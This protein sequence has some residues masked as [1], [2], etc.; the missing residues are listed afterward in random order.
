MIVKYWGITKENIQEKGKKEENYSLMNK[1][2]IW[3]Q[4]TICT[5]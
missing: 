5:S 2:Q 1:G 3:D 4:Y